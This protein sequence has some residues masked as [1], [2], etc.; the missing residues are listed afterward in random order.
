MRNKERNI[1]IASG[2][3]FLGVLIFMIIKNFLKQEPEQP[4]DEFRLFAEEE[5]EQQHGVEY[6]SMK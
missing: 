3:G 4:S 5:V 2:I 1:L 6:F